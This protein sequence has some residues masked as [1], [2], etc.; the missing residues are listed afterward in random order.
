MDAE[1]DQRRRGAG[2]TSGDADHELHHRRGKEGRVY[3]SLEGDVTIMGWSSGSGLFA[4]IAEVIADT[5]ADE[6]DRRIIY[7]AMIEAFMDRDCDT[8]EECVG[9]DHVLDEVLVESSSEE[10]DEDDEE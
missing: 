1:V 8:L 2:S 10:E 6:D 3:G 5:V 4:E 7:E 9:I